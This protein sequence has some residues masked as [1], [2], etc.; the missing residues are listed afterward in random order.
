MCFFPQKIKLRFI[1]AENK[2]HTTIHIFNNFVDLYNISAMDFFPP[3][4][5]VTVQDA[6]SDSKELFNQ[7]TSSLSSSFSEL[8]STMD[9]LGIA[10]IQIDSYLNA[11]G[12]QDHSNSYLKAEAELIGRMGWPGWA[13][14]TILTLTVMLITTLLFEFYWSRKEVKAGR[15]KKNVGAP[16]GFR[17]FQLSYLAV[18]LTIML[19]DWLQGTNMYTL[20]DGYGVDIGS[21]FITG[22]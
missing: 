21:L 12:L 2:V 16:P 14:R 8:S 4:V 5:V 20:Y 18:Y 17:M 9:S 15:K 13:V 11:L 22:I 10:D 19:A 3:E 6:I 7:F 1:S